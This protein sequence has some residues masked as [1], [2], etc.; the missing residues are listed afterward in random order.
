[1]ADEGTFGAKL[2][3][4]RVAA[5]LSISELS[6][7]I[8]YS[9]AQISRVETGQSTPT[10]AFAA[11]CDQVFGTSGELVQ[12]AADRRKQVEARFDP[13][14]G[15]ARLVG[16]ET[17][18]AALLGH[19][20]ASDI[21]RHTPSIAALH[22]M[23][24]VGKTAIATE[25]VR[26]LR[27]DFPDG[28]LYLD[29][30]GYHPTVAPVTAADALDRII[31]RLG[32]P[33][34]HMPK[35]PDERAALFRELL[36][37]RSMLLLLDNVR[38][39]EQVEPLLP[40]NA[41]SALLITGR[42]RLSALDDALQWPVHSLRLDDA[43]ELFHDVARLP[44]ESAARGDPALVHRIVELCGGLPL[45]IRII[46]ARFTEDPTRTLEDTTALLT[47]EHSRLQEFDDGDRSV[48]TALATSYAALPVTQQRAL[49]VV[50]LH[51]GPRVDIA[52]AAALFGNTP[53]EAARLLDQLVRAAV[54]ERHARGAHRLHDLLRAY[55]RQIPS[56]ILT[57]GGAAAQRSLFD[58]YLRTAA[59]AD[60]IIAKDR[61]HISL[62]LAPH[63]RFEVTFRDYDS[64][65]KWMV[66]ELENFLPL[67]KEM[68]RLEYDGVCWQFA[69]CLRGYFFVSKQWDT[70]IEA[71]GIALAA[72]RRLGDRRAEAMMLINLGLASDELGRKDEAGAYYEQAREAFTDAKDEHGATNT[73]HNL[74]W[75]EYSRGNFANALSLSQQALAFYESTGSRSNFAIAIDCM[76]R[77]QHKLGMRQEA[78]DR[79][80]EALDLFIELEFP[81]V[82]IAQLHSSLGRT[83]IEVGQH[84]A[85]AHN[86]RKAI[87]YARQGGGLYEEA[88]ALEG[89]GDTASAVGREDEAVMHK[90]AAQALYEAIGAPDAD[91]LRAYRVE[92]VTPAHDTEVTEDAVGAPEASQASADSP[93][94]RVLAINDEWSSQYG[95]V[96]NYNRLL[97]IALASAGA[98]V[99]CFVRDV[100]DKDQ[101][102]AAA[103]GVTLVGGRPSVGKTSAEP[104]TR[105]PILPDN[106]VPDVVIGHGR[107]TG[108]YAIQL[109]E[110]HYQD[111]KRIHF[112][113]VVSDD[114]E[115][116]KVQDEH[117]PMRLAEEYTSDELAFAR[118]AFRAVGV[119]PVLYDWL[120]QHLNGTGRPP[121]RLDPGFDLV[122]DHRH[123]YQPGEIARILMAG[124]MSPRESLIKGL[125]LAAGALG[126]ALELRDSDDQEVQLI[127]RG[128]PDG[129]GKEIHAKV[130]EWAERPGLRVLPRAYA[131]TETLQRDLR[132][133]MLVL[134][135][136]RAEGFGLVGLEAVVAGTPVLVSLTSGLGKL[137]RELLPTALAQQV[138]IPI[139]GNAIKDKQRWGHAIATA[140][141]NPE[142]AFAAAQ[143]IR[144]TM[145]RK[146][147]WAMAA[148]TLLD[149]IRSR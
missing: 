46:A 145:A 144:T 83:M 91:R 4:V 108:H 111:A 147:T 65:M 76:A 6:K 107:V 40:P 77:A 25:V 36:S 57:D 62:S 35:E 127:V 47:D 44:R 5:K 21:P 124:R 32:V 8:Y 129:Q 50:A 140:L 12:L 148:R 41:L 1:M 122:D 133:S 134:M 71:Y 56:S 39:L 146:R 104:L 72:A 43:A 86:Y 18:V 120:C 54:V 93:A 135:P 28:C 117:D 2:R 82:D 27:Y 51:P 88:L 48:V 74:A 19:L 110:D 98:D 116:D 126:F 131:S 112:L 37:G 78:A 132:Q 101:R 105:R 114:V 58:H 29:L 102:D 75:L 26:R 59:A 128:V 55:L 53:G 81:P 99:Y 13:P 17:D 138:T 123:Q 16:R 149:D 106:V 52:G 24:G 15:P 97:C 34:R 141:S 113:H 121:L 68:H 94:L 85:A 142:V 109:V 7:L 60:S 30:H 69:Y 90:A 45:A 70:W 139:T 67:I 100:S 137:L 92:Q 136:S 119:G 49:S 115:F 42:N 11:A 14:V 73:V 33:G 118:G 64:A 31:R 66:E 79:F 84:D 22:G 89:L 96:S 80:Q 23:A 9:K 63:P 20:R 87:G 10:A 38:W 103:A 143:D 130:L 61:Y 3:L 95:G 125:D